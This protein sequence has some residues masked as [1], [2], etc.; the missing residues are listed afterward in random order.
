MTPTELNEGVLESSQS[1]VDNGKAVR[2]ESREHGKNSDNSSQPLFSE[3]TEDTTVISKNSNNNDTTPKP[4][5]RRLGMMGP[6]F[7]K[8]KLSVN[9]SDVSVELNIPK[10]QSV[11]QTGMSDRKQVVRKYMC[12]KCP[13]MF[14]TKSGYERHLLK[15]HK[16]RNVA[17]YEP[18]II[19][20]IRKIFGPHSYETT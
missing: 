13:E 7:T 5:K 17:E 3:A 4:N 19:E 9:L 12:K 14:F 8:L 10:E 1:N 16:I 15:I 6:A 2:N 20:K 18:E 11:V